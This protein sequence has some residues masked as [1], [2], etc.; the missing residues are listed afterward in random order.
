MGISP[1]PEHDIEEGVIH[2]GRQVAEYDNRAPRSAGYFGD[3]A[4]ILEQLSRIEQKLEA[5]DRIEQKLDRLLKVL[6]PDK[7]LWVAP[8]PDGTV[9]SE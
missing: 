7:G 3:T 9:K 2:F 4:L 6:D 8:G 1:M 5:L